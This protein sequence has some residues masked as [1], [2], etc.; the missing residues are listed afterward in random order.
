MHMG[1]A[2]EALSTTVEQVACSRFG[3]VLV[4]V[5]ANHRVVSVVLSCF[6]KYLLFVVA[7]TTSTLFFFCD[8]LLSIVVL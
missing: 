3:V 6:V 2:L 8:F 1:T 4:I 5:V 7:E